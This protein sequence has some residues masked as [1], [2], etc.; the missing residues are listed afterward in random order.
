MDTQKTKLS[1]DVNALTAYPLRSRCLA[2]HLSKISEAS[3]T[4]GTEK[5]RERDINN[6]HEA[7]CRVLPKFDQVWPR[8]ARNRLNLDRL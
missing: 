4:R 6:N 3:M 5:E 7:I 1:V 2:G 8:S